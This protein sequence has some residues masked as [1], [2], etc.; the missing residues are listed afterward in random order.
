M[1]FK[2]NHIKSLVN[3]LGGEARFLTSMLTSHFKLLPFNN[4]YII[5]SFFLHRQE[6]CHF[7]GQGRFT[8]GADTHIADKPIL[9]DHEGC[10]DG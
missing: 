10:R 6:F 7:H 2:E 3:H 8:D 1:I 9:V 5:W 4:S